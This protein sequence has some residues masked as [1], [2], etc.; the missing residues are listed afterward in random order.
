[1]HEGRAAEK[2][3]CC[4]SAWVSNMPA[5]LVFH[6]SLHYIPQ[7]YSPALFIGKHPHRKRLEYP[8]LFSQ[9]NA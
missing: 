2:I 1:M 5:P 9:Y 3:K 6:S 7:S 8:F 4:Q